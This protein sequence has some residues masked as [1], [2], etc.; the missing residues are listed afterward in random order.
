MALGEKKQNGLNGF[1][2][3]ENQNGLSVKHP[4]KELLTDEFLSKPGKLILLS[5]GTIVSSHTKVMNELID[6]I[7]ALPHKFIVSCG[8]SFEKITLPGI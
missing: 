7:G 1:T 8:K 4:G 6:I 3:K 5:M 2:A